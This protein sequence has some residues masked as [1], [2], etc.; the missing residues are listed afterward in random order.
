MHTPPQGLCELRQSRPRIRLF[1]A[2][3]GL[4]LGLISGQPSLASAG[5]EQ[6]GNEVATS[7]VLNTLGAA[8]L[9]EGKE[10]TVSLGIMEI[11]RQA[12]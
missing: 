7:G 9:A 6:V 8:P 3:V 10:I 2:G 11:T 5:A 1:L 12:G 4:V